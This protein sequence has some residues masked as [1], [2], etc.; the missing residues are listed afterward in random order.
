M[1]SS[2]SAVSITLRRDWPWPTR[3]FN[4]SRAYFQILV[5]RILHSLSIC[6]GVITI[7]TALGR[8]LV[9]RRRVYR[10]IRGRLCWLAI[11]TDDKD[12]GLNR[13][14][15]SSAQPSS[16]RKTLTF[17]NKSL[18]A[19]IFCIVTL[20]KCALWIAQLRLLQKKQCCALRVRKSSLIGMPTPARCSPQ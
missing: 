15:I 3:P 9:W 7:T 17:S 13:P 4:R 20:I 16:I 10:T 2:I 1:I 5:K 6:T 12:A 18:P 14:K 11:S 19:I 8:N